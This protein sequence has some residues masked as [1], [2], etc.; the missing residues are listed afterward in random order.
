MGVVRF[1]KPPR[2]ATEFE[3]V[4]DIGGSKVVCFLVREGEPGD[5]ATSEVLGVGHS[6]FA[7]RENR[8][9]DIS[10]VEGSVRIAV[11]GAERMAGRRVN[12]VTL[13]VSG[14][15]LRTRRVGVDLELDAGVITEEDIAESLAA[16]AG[17]AVP[18][19]F[20]LVHALPV[21]FAVDGEQYF[22]EPVGLVGDSLSTEMVGVSA[23]ESL[24]ENFSELMS[25]C[26]LNVRRF[27]ASPIAAAA[28]SLDPDEL[29][30]GVVLIDLGSASTE[31][32]VFDHG[33]AIDMGGIPM[34]GSLITNDIAKIFGASLASAERIKTLHGS[35]LHGPGD[36]HRFVDIEL[37]GEQGET[38]RTSKAEITD[39]IRPRLEEIFEL[40]D[41]RLPKDPAQRSGI[42]RAVL[43]G[44]G[45]L[46]LGANEICERVLGL[47]CRVGRP[48]SLYGAPEAVAGPGFA[49]CAGLALYNR[50]LKLRS[51]DDLGLA[52]NRQSSY[53][54]TVTGLAN[55]GA[56]FRSRF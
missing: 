56:W 39:I 34:G 22:A 50:I 40:I 48:V 36:E 13:S 55:F 8:L 4:I 20:S 12:D 43:V 28:S 35:A 16:G 46:L 27:V 25:R 52:A 30:L 42:R 9:P 6:G 17:T 29:E 45:S 19:G 37:L 41:R 53:R 15:F 2:R 24:L 1:P 47:K 26:D 11:D 38:M 18:D 32:I 10:A 23:R 49:T 44:G 7:L 51:G 21:S 33:A 31:F 14:R 3:A 54:R 5:F